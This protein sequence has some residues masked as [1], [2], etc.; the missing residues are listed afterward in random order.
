MGIAVLLLSACVGKSKNSIESIVNDW[1]GRSVVFPEKLAFTKLGKDT[2]RKTIPQ[3]DFYVLTYVDS[4]G[5]ISCKLQLNNWKLFIADMKNLKEKTVAV[6]FFI[7]SKSEGA[8]LQILE[9]SKF[10]YPVCF[11]SKDSLNIL[12]HFPSNMA[13]QTF[14][15]DKHK[16]VMAIGNPIYSPSVKKLYTNIITGKELM[17][18]NESIVQTEITVNR[19]IISLGTFLWKDKQTADF[20]LKNV[21]ENQLVIENV[22]TSCGCATVEYSQEPVRPGKDVNL[23]VIY[24]AD[25]PE[26]FNKT[27]TVYCNANS[28]PLRLTI[29][30]NAE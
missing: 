27:I 14:L 10:V 7:N 13:F 18:K 29:S 11:D 5:C 20:I 26:H 16:K 25:H 9:E 23:H 15:L 17:Q 1:S 24:K 21:G 6:L 8:M 19:T 3:A 30:G 22:T 12:N 4:I 2:V 28:S